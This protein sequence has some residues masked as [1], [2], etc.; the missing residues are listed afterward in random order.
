MA[1][2][3]VILAAGYGSRFLPVTRCVPK[4]MLPIVN[5]PALDLVVREFAEAGIEDVLVITSRRKRAIEDWFDRDPELETVFADK[6]SVRGRIRPPEVRATFVR[7]QE[8][9]GTGE[10]LLLAREFAGSD[11]V[12]LAF[13]DDLF[14]SPNCTADMIQVW[15]R[16]GKSVLAAAD[17]SGE[18]VSRYGVIDPSGE[19]EGIVHVRSVVEKPA[20][21]T[22]PS[23]LVSLGRYLFA[24]DIFSALAEGL[25]AHQGPGE[26]FATDGINRL[27]E[28]GSVVA[29]II[30]APRYDTGTPL[31]YMKAIVEL[32]L[33]HD[34]IGEEFS[35]WLQERFAG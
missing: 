2:K 13:P 25:A 32:G 33:Q 26:Y 4:E 14:G 30:T 17:L 19:E 16:T 15:E 21:G 22:E 28:Q 20:P 31:G 35:R 11:A 9:R 23:S 34:D 27:A 12:V 10:A 6:P 7:Q 5:R 24:P 29:R 18:D 1:V 8:M 3:G